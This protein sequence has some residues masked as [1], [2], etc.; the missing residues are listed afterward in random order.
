M[1]ERMVKTKKNLKASQDRNYFYVDKGIIHREFKGGDHVLLKV[2]AKRS[3]L[4]LGNFPKLEA[5]YFGPFEILER[6]GLVAYM[7]AL[8]A[9]MRIHNVF[10]VSFLK[11]YVPDTNHVIDWNVIQVK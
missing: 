3:S 8:P 6:N 9:S 11:N 1:E 7:L 10:H 4:K 5:R 2:K